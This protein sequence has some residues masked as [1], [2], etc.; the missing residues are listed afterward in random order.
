MHVQ[1][2]QELCA[3]NLKR[4]AESCQ[5]LQGTAASSE[6]LT[7]KKRPLSSEANGRNNRSKKPKIEALLDAV[8]DNETSKSAHIAKAKEANKPPL[9]NKD[10]DMMFR[11]K[12]IAEAETANKRI[13]EAEKKKDK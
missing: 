12:S 4:H 5:P 11:L 1:I 13:A 7:V 8:I 2:A 6:G 3:D 9:Q 10:D